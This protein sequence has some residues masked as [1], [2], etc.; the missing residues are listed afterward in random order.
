M[1]EFFALI[2]LGS[3]IAAAVFTG[4]KAKARYDDMK[5]NFKRLS[6]KVEWLDKDVARIEKDVALIESKLHQLLETI[7]QHGPPRS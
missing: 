4:Y 2:G 3:V 5:F 7:A 6:S 1:M